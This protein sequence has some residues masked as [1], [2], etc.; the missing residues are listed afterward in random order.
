MYGKTNQVNFDAKK[1][2][3]AGLNKL[4]DAVGSTLGPK[5]RLVALPMT[6]GRVITT[7]D[8]VTVSNSIFLEDPVENFGAQLCK[9]V[10]QQ[11]N[12]LCGDGTTTSSILA[13]S[14][15][16]AGMRY[17]AQG[18]SA[19]DLKRGID[20][21]IDAV[22][23]YLDEMKTKVESTCLKDLEFVASIA[24][25]EKAI[26]SIVAEAYN[27]IGED[28]VVTI[29]N[30][31]T[32]SNELIIHEGY[33]FD[34]GWLSPYFCNDPET[35][36]VDFKE[37]DEPSVLVWEDRIMDPKEVLAFLDNYLRGQT[38]GVKPLLIVSDEVEG[39]ALRTI[40]VNAASPQSP[41]RGKIAVVKAP[42]FG[43]RK[44]GLL[45][46]LATISGAKFYSKELGQK[47]SNVVIANLGKVKQVLINQNSTTIIRLDSTNEAVDKQLETLKSRFDSSDS[48]YDKEKYTERIS[49]L[50]GKVAVIR[51]GASTESELIE[52]KHRFEDAVQEGIVPGGGLALVKV[53]RK[54]KKPAGLTEGEAAGWQ[55][56]KEA[57]LAPTK[58][59][60]ENAGYSGEVVA[61]RLLSARQE[62]LGFD[63]STGQYVDLVQEGIIDPVKVTRHALLNA[64]SIAGV[65]LLTDTVISDVEDKKNG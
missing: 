13:Q 11:T 15:A 16:N 20:K 41:L 8:G 59:I 21:A 65:F 26:G 61:A 36:S 27:K 2:T 44:I 42:G 19:T 57:L 48:N 40:V 35:L 17:I 64:A 9:Q 33:T 18:G 53:M 49:K 54:L 14:L 4:A 3:L 24:G 39:E 63:A 1:K 12:D 46:D 34:R 5:G 43:D 32:R 38:N 56:V 31:Q 45:E 55:I 28:G 50:S 6:Y 51:V 52:K 22:L 37:E 58:L 60:A 10:A 23:D 25:N 29:E 47:L 7:K 62:N 30:S